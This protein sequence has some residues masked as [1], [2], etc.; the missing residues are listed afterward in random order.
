MGRD[1]NICLPETCAM[2]CSCM[3]MWMQPDF[4][5]NI[6]MKR[7]PRRNPGQHWGKINFEIVFSKTFNWQNMYWE[8]QIKIS[9][10]IKILVPLW[11]KLSMPGRI[12]VTTLWMPFIEVSDAILLLEKFTYKFISR[13]LYARHSLQFCMYALFLQGRGY[14]SYCV[15]QRKTNKYQQTIES[16]YC[17]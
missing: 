14:I 11:K 13:V 17:K 5:S 16:I 2:V 4:L 9:E 10:F 15:S 6:E 3:Q 8:S 12:E 7:S 1:S